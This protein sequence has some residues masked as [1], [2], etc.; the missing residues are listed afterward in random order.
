[1]GKYL[2]TA[3]ALFI[4][5]GQVSAQIETG[6]IYPG[7]KFGQGK[8]VQYGFEPSL[9]IGLGKHGLLGFYSNYIRGSNYYYNG[10]MTYGIQKGVGIN[11][12]YFRFFKNSQ[13]LGWFT[14]I[15][16]EYFTSNVYMV[17]NGIKEL[18]NKYGQTDLYLKPGIFFKASPKVTLFTNFGGIG[19][20]SSRGNNDLDLSFLSEMNIGVL[21]NINSGKKKK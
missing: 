3:A 21:I 14:T 19:L 11:Y 6:K 5:Y 15:G 10:I 12:T 18:N 9:S 2:F 4:I 20:S 17:K 16:A 7:I 13:R 8:A 1:M